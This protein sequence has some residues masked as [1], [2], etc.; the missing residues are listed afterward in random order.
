VLGLPANWTE[1]LRAHAA[2]RGFDLVVVQQPAVAYAALSMAMQQH[3]PVLVFAWCRYSSGT[4]EDARFEN[5]DVVRLCE[6]GFEDALLMA[7]MEWDEA[8]LNRQVEAVEEP[9]GP[10]FASVRLAYEQAAV[11]FAEL[12]F[13]DAARQSAAESP[14]QP[15]TAVYTILRR[16]NEIAQRWLANEIAPPLDPHFREAGL[17]HS[18]DIS[19]MSKIKFGAHY[20]RT[21]DGRSIMLGP[22]VKRGKS[23]PRQCLRIYYWRDE[24][25]RRIVVGHI[26]RHL[27]TQ[28]DPH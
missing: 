25:R 2:A 11:D 26:G 9:P 4:E 18:S 19:T 17:V 24:A 5:T 10:E 6:D 12:V 21:Y 20:E 3:D 8:A 27:P 14:Y 1:Q 28:A 7:G 15:A 22:H 16:M 23:S 13:L